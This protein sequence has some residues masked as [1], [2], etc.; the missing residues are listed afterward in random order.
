M[1][2]TNGMEN[3]EYLYNNRNEAEFKF[4]RRGDGNGVIR[5]PVGIALNPIE[6]MLFVCDM[7]SNRIQVFTAD[8]YLV[9]SFVSNNLKK[10]C[11]IAMYRNTL[12]VTDVRIH[13]LVQFRNYSVRSTGKCGIRV[14]ELQ[15][16]RSVTCDNK[17]DVFVTDCNNA[18]IVVYS[19]ELRVKRVI[20][21]KVAWSPIDARIF[22]RELIVLS[23]YK[24]YIHCYT[25][26]TKS[27]R[28]VNQVDKYV[29]KPCFFCVDKFGNFVINDAGSRRIVITNH[30]GKLLKIIGGRNTFPAMFGTQVASFDKIFV[31]LCNSPYSISV[32]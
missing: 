3:G 31:V 10:P 1:E 12:Y 32:I 6:T 14:G 4:G 30:T 18:R 26:A 2:E 8:G 29:V 9:T 24:P 25:L 20:R 21:S 7:Q 16:P 15:F 5:M 11:G 13:S 19:E 17:G 28:Y 23:Q 22:D 27:V